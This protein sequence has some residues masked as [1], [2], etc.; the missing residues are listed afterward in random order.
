MNTSIEKQMVPTCLTC[1]T[2]ICPIVTYLKLHVS[3]WCVVKLNNLRS[4]L[5]SRFWSQ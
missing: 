2:T 1:V 3:I 5:A 4:G